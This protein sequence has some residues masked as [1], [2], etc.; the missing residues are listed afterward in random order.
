VPWSVIMIAP[1]AAQPP[2]TRPI[3]H[4][5]V[6]RN[7]FKAPA[8]THCYTASPPN[9]PGAIETDHNTII[10]GGRNH[11]RNI[12]FLSPTPLVILNPQQ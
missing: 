5:A 9:N 1:A 3:H 4:A 10:K 2:G 7:S 12:L 11:L 6:A 8:G